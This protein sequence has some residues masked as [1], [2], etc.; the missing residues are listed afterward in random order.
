[1]RRILPIVLLVATLAACDSERIDP[2]ETFAASSC[3]SIQTWVDAVED[4]TTQLS[5]AVTPLEHASD[6]VGYYRIF[7]RALV[8]R[9][10]DT[11][12]QLKRLAPAAGDGRAA[13]DVFI[14]AMERTKHVTEQLVTLADSF[15]DGDDDPEP[16]ISRISSLLIRME[17]GFSIPSKARDALA[18]RYPV[19]D[20]IPACVD[21]DE[22]VT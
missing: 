10:D 8:E 6:R 15:P 2:L 7:A 18:K 11:I 20:Q 21:Y 12:R 9:T 4:Y 22:P 5:H 14:D 17:K 16:L 1:V 19:F 3:A 13:A